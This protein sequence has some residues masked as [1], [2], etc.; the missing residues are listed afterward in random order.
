MSISR[1]LREDVVVVLRGSLRR[2][3]ER[4]GRSEMQGGGRRSV[5][6]MRGLGLGVRG[7]ASRRRVEDQGDM[8]WV[9][10]AWEKAIEEVL[11]WCGGG[12]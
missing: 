12:E 1:T 8:L 10:M 6:G 3:R 4:S 9:R 11:R 7:L 5:T 2:I